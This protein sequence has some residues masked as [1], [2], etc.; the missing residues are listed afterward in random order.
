M[1]GQSNQNRVVDNG[2]SVCRVT[3]NNQLFCPKHTFLVGP[4]SQKI[5]LLIER[6]HS[7]HRM[8]TEF[9]VSRDVFINCSI[10]DKFLSLFVC[11]C[12]SVDAC[13]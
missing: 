10:L 3:S 2:G 8:Q 4:F 6:L 13:H 1:S 11:L 12:L 9:H 7:S 5:K